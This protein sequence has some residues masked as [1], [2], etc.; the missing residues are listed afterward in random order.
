MVLTDFGCAAER[1]ELDGVPES[2]SHA[3]DADR[4][5][6]AARYMAPEMLSGEAN[7]GK[8]V[9]WWSLG[10]LLFEMLCGEPPYM[11]AQQLHA[12]RKLQPQDP[13]TQ[14]PPLVSPS[15]CALIKALLQ[16]QPDLRLGAGDRG[17]LAVRNHHFFVPM[18]WARL[19]AKQEEP[20]FIPNA[21]SYPAATWQELSKQ[22]KENLVQSV[23]NIVPVGLRKVLLGNIA[24][25]T[26]EQLRALF[27]TFGPVESVQVQSTRESSQLGFGFVTFENPETAEEVIAMR[28]V[29]LLG[30]TIEIK[31]CQQQTSKPQTARQTAMQEQ[32]PQLPKRQHEASNGTII[33]LGPE[34]PVIK[35]QGCKET[36]QLHKPAAEK[37]TVP[38]AKSRSKGLK[39]TSTR[40]ETHH[41]GDSAGSFESAPRQMTISVEFQTVVLVLLAI[42]T[43]LAFAVLALASNARIVWWDYQMD[44]Y[45]KQMDGCSGMAGE[46]GHEFSHQCQ[47]GKCPGRPSEDISTASLG[48]ECAG[49]ACPPG[50]VCEDSASDPT[51][52]AGEHVCTCDTKWRDCNGVI[53]CGMDI[54]CI[55]EGRNVFTGAECQS[56]PCLN[57][58]T[59]Y[60]STHSSNV[61]VGE[62]LC[63]CLPER[64]GANCEYLVLGAGEQH[65]VGLSNL[66]PLSHV[67]SSVMLSEDELALDTMLSLISSPLRTTHACV[68]APCQRNA[69]C[70]PKDESYSCV[71]TGGWEGDNCETQSAVECPYL[72]AAQL[73]R[74]PNSQHYLGSPCNYN[75]CIVHSDGCECLLYQWHYCS[76]P[77]LEVQDPFCASLLKGILEPDAQGWLETCMHEVRVLQSRDGSGSG[78]ATPFN[79]L[80]LTR[81]PTDYEFID[82]VKITFSEH[83]PLGL[84]LRPDPQTGA[85]M[86][87]EVTPGT[88]A[89]H[90]QRLKAGMVLRQIGDTAVTNQLYKDIL[91]MLTRVSKKRPL[92]LRFGTYINESHVKPT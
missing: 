26:A 77:G 3:G 28:T 70:Q 54:D 81:P 41:A 64:H 87:L 40:P 14:F 44:E 45:T 11:D 19:L 49:V 43:L 7:F 35:Q 56:Q 60:D 30:H 55:S 88:Q 42:S 46:L 79:L 29:C 23:R 91:K 33:Q 37:G 69:T 9:D 90:H 48:S 85:P 67:Q 39:A 62:Y 65:Y 61:K 22:S 47:H 25:L 2:Q 51:L 89:A 76:Q 21:P 66:H 32:S 80:D 86:V 12:V 8:E 82:E 18:E 17:S 27:E 52:H 59:C 34:D 38:D 84:K 58:G 68:S 75:A 74:E 72:S 20:P 53:I 73:Y 92:V 63:R 24:D 31:Q 16:P 13:G 6:I 4:A 36:D 15:A 5:V 57:G 71:C 10:V 50:S 78:H 1:V 83:G